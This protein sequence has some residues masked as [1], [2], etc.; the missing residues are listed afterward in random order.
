M[1]WI[2]AG[3]PNATAWTHTHVP[4]V[5]S[6]MFWALQHLRELWQSHLQTLG[7]DQKYHEQTSSLSLQLAGRRLQG[8]DIRVFLFQKKE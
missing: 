8:R 7:N 1:G 4:P 2:R 6:R 3:D 5:F